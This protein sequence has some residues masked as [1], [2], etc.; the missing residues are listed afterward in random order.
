MQQSFDAW[1]DR[2]K[3]ILSREQIEYGYHTEDETETESNGNAVYDTVCQLMGNFK[4]KCRVQLEKMSCKGAQV[5]DRRSCCK[6]LHQ[7]NL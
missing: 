5:E 2:L 4:Y 7:N 1:T 3:K 6:N